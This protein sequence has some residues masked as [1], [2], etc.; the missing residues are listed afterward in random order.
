MD[1][2][3]QEKKKKGRAP[4]IELFIIFIIA[5]LVYL[6]AVYTNAHQA[7]NI[8]AGNKRFA[9]LELNELF[10]LLIFLGVAF[11][12]F[13]MRRWKEANREI[14]ERKRAEEQLIRQQSELKAINLELSVLYKVASTIS[15]TIDMDEL[16]AVVLDTI[17][18]LE[19]LNVEHKGGI[20]FIEGDRMTLVSHLGHSEEFLNLHK[21]MKVGDC[22]CGLAAKTGEIIISKNCENDSRHT[23]KYPG[24]TPHGHII[25][26]L[27]VRG[28]VVGVLYL[29][30]LANIEIDERVLKLLH[31]IGNQI[32]VAISNSR[33]YE[34]TKI[35]S[36]R[37]SLT[38]VANRNLMNIE[39]EKN[40]ARAK[41]LGS[42][43]SVIMLDLDN[44]K[45]YNDTYGHAA[46]DK[47]L[48]ETANVLLNEVRA[49][50]LVV[51]YGG[52]EFLILL[53]DTELTEAYEVAER[54]RKTVE[55]KAG[56]TISLGV[57]SHQHEMQKREDLIK[58]ADDALYQAK[59]KGKN[60]VEISG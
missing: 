21:D 2:N 32:G 54:I 14:I 28:S 57:S 18:G 33:H 47:L 58:K 31:A 10:V 16:F 27:E 52:E 7:V 43:F 37:D 17:T 6:I 11:S 23:I 5:A 34:Q 19:L 45:K 56:N 36:L 13:G 48:I 12:V 8:W 41:R 46:G 26:P 53:P 25:I 60:R 59:Q 24:I 9:G 30:L 51:R 22:L 29:Y 55:A 20:F 39:L 35:L 50:D 40:F 1:N 38:K 44:F 3:L 4:I 15:Q 49:I 42:P